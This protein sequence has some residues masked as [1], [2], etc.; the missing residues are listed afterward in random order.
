MSSINT[1]LFPKVARR[2]ESIAS[3]NQA[4]ITAINAGETL[5][6]GTVFWADDQTAGRGQGGNR[7]FSSPNANLALSI[8][9]YPDHLLADR[10]FSLTQ[11]AAI[12]VAETVV[13]HLPEEQASKVRI[14]WPNDVYVGDRKIAGILVQNGLRGS[15]VSWSVIGVGLNVNERAFPEALANTATSLFLL[16]GSQYDRDQVADSLF[17][18]FSEAYLLTDPATTRELTIR[19]HE[20]L[21]L[22]GVPASY[23]AVATGH[24]FQ[25]VL[26]GVDALGRLRLKT[27]TGEQVFSLREVR[28]VR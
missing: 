9:S 28:F 26:T 10:I 7:W 12:A 8:I 23:L 6:P 1:P 5:A 4:A 16:S 3:T 2:Y 18:A 11:A 24:T 22:K 27:P 25:A 21:Y 14:K 19:Y 20:Q 13:A 15:R 17:S